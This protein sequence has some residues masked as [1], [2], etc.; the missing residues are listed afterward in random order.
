MTEY[1]YLL[2]VTALCAMVLWCL[3]PTSESAERPTPCASSNS[4]PSEHSVSSH[5]VQ[6][7]NICI[8]S[9]P[10]RARSTTDNVIRNAIPSSAIPTYRVTNVAHNPAPAETPNENDLL[11]RATRRRP[12]NSSMLDSETPRRFIPRDFGASPTSVTRAGT[13]NTV[14]VTTSVTLSNA[15]HPAALREPAASGIHVCVN[16]TEPIS[17]SSPIAVP[18][19]YEC[20][21]LSSDNVLP[22]PPGTISIG[23]EAAP[24]EPQEV[25]P[26]PRLRRAR[27]SKLDEYYRRDSEPKDKKLDLRMQY[28]DE[29]M[30]NFYDFY[31]RMKKMYTH[32]GYKEEDRYIYVVTG[33]GIF[34]ENM[35]PK[36]KPAVQSFLDEKKVRHRWLNRG[37]L[38]MIDFCGEAD[39]ETDSEDNQT[40]SEEE[41]SNYETNEESPMD[42]DGQLDI[43]ES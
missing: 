33:Y 31:Y 29:A 43:I 12:R 26:S 15:S 17:S 20:R 11:A 18:V 40:D 23:A 5:Q 6:P 13:S 32:E 2:F 41:S 19:Y 34:S 14:L 21:H 10:S 3:W 28:L 9:F 8:R 30:A 4:L 36:I 37:G 38:V 7:L 16:D 25:P 39:E 27:R 42:E 24:C 1:L 22:K 35:I